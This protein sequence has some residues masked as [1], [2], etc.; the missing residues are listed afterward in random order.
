MVAGEEP[1]E[2]RQRVAGQ[3]LGL[4]QR[5][6]GLEDVREVVQAQRHVGMVAGEEPLVHRQRVAVERLGLLQRT[7]GLEDVRQV[8]QADCH[9]GMVAGEQPLV[10]RQRL[11][12]K[13]LG[14]LQRAAGLKDGRE[15]VQASRDGGMLFEREPAVDRELTPGEARRALVLTLRVKGFKVRFPRA[16]R[17]P[18]PPVSAR[19]RSHVLQRRHNLTRVDY[20]V[21]IRRLPGGNPDLRGPLGQSDGFLQR[22][23]LRCRV[24]AQ[25]TL[26]LQFLDARTDLVELLR[27][28]LRQIRRLRPPFR[29]LQV[30][31]NL[32][33]RRD[34]RAALDDL[35]HRRR[36]RALDVRV[37]VERLPDLQELLITHEPLFRRLRGVNVDAADQRAGRFRLFLL[38]HRRRSRDRRATKCAEIRQDDS[39]RPAA[40]RRSP[41]SSN[42]HGKLLRRLVAPSDSPDMLCVRFSECDSARS[43]VSAATQLKPRRR[44]LRPPGAAARRPTLPAKLF[45][46]PDPFPALVPDGCNYPTLRPPAAKE[47]PRCGPYDDHR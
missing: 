3:R 14:P 30:I 10:H 47:T 13:R 12:E 11:T 34:R 40:G 16:R 44:P 36:I 18:S 31:K 32:L 38:R 39:K 43:S 8:V 42:A 20:L 41:R 27:H 2:H 35:R 46:L 33:Q 21:P 22:P 17:G 25:C 23:L 6:A 4:L 1:L 29:M 5:T 28:P 15:A 19:Q 26:L 9:V 45:A 7:A 37:E 24:I